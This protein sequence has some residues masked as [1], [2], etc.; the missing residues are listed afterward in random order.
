MSLQSP[1]Q[2]LERPSS[3]QNLPALASGSQGM[4]WFLRRTRIPGELAKFY[5]RGLG[6]PRLRSW[7]VPSTA[8]DMLWCGDVGVVEL[9]RLDP[10]TKLEPERS[11]CL[12]VF[13][14][15]DLQ[16]SIAR[17]VDAGA[18]AV[19]SVFP[20][21][22]NILGFKDPDGFIFGFERADLQANPP[23]DPA[24]RTWPGQISN[25][26]GG[27]SI[28]GPIQ[29]LTKVIHFTSDPTQE[30]AFLQHMGFSQKSANSVS[31]GGA[32]EIVIEPSASSV[33]HAPIQN[34]EMAHDTW[35]A[36]VY[37]VENYRSALSSRDGNLLSSHEF[38]GGVLDYALSPSNI[39]IGWQERKPYDPDI[40]TTQMIEDLAARTHWINR[41]RDKSD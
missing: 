11:P 14:T 27:V 33:K 34:R 17:A 31:L 23:L 15:L 4:G 32:T 41:S 28:D 22:M 40:P 37:G 6:L 5:E 9:N 39:L 25:L 35:I 19:D 16:S 8:G 12:P 21:Q 38:A 3:E 36:R 7:D 2:T 29:C 18:R 10:N 24:D 20:E 13:S 30:L 26:P 1:A